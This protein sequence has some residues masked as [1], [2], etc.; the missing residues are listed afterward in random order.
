MVD[1]NI[2]DLKKLSEEFTRR[3]EEAVEDGILTK[4]ENDDLLI[5]IKQIEVMAMN[6][7]ILTT[8]E[9]EIIRDVQQK[10]ARET[11]DIRKEF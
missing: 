1:D 2:E 8:K 10:L 3:L 6:D 11:K 5:K 4:E 7:Y 9:K